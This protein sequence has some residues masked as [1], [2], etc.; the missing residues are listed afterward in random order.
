MTIRTA[1][2]RHYATFR[3]PTEE[4]VEGD[5]TLDPFI[6]DFGAW[7]QI[8]PVG[9]SEETIGEQAM[10]SRTHLVTMRY[11]SRVDSRMRLH[12]RSRVFE[13][14]SPPLNVDERDIELQLMCRE[15]V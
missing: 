5:T 6:E 8:Q 12:V 7:I 10:A 3:L 9:G 1:E 11:D 15:L 4:I 2:L 14:V 13:I